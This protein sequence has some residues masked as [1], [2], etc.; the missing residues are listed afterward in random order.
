MPKLSRKN[1]QR[2]EN[3]KGVEEIPTATCPELFA[4][5]LN[6][7]D[8][9]VMFLS[10]MRKVS[11]SKLGRE[12]ENTQKRDLLVFLFSASRQMSE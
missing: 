1:Y 12:T 9:E 8:Q 4:Q 5:S 7:S 6:N 10:F 11:S 2:M 3:G